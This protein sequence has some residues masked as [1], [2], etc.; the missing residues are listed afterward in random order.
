MG[1]SRIEDAR[2]SY[3]WICNECEE[4]FEPS[5][6]GHSMIGRHVM[7]VHDMKP[8]DSVRGLIDTRTGDVLWAGWG[9]R[10]QQACGT[11]GYLID[12]PTE[13]EEAEEELPPPSPR[14]KVKEP[15]LTRREKQLLTIAEQTGVTKMR[16]VVI[17]RSVEILFLEA[18]GL[19]P[20]NYGDNS[21]DSMS[22][23][24]EDF[25]VGYA[26]MQGMYGGRIIAQEVANRIVLQGGLENG[27]ET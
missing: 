16:D 12:W 27:D 10:V 25:V 20:E 15:P 2:D 11:R 4:E 21:K 6:K 1:V 14:I 9:P 22:R 8:K 5:T 26:I 17:P 3:R 24:I 19:W 23:F 7:A 13:P 18:Q